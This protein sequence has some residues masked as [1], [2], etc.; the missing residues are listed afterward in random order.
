MV[1]LLGWIRARRER[2]EM[3]SLEARLETEFERIMEEQR[4]TEAMIRK[5]WVAHDATTSRS[6]SFTL[7]RKINV[8]I[9]RLKGLEN[10]ACLAERH[11]RTIVK[12]RGSLRLGQS[13]GHH[14]VRPEQIESAIDQAEA[15]MDDLRAS[16]ERSVELDA[17]EYQD[18]L[19]LTVATSEDPAQGDGERERQWSDDHEKERPAKAR[20]TELG[21]GTLTRLR[22]LGMAASANAET[23]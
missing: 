23:E 18:K 6:V 9:D 7:E 20:G 1:D 2:T 3:A 16:D 17:L 12:V 15:A 14:N 4:E 8:L 5:L 21:V 22:E 13:A 19:R 10:E 11:G